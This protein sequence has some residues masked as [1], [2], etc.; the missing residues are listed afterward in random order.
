M[1][2]SR[3]Y[4][5]AQKQSAKKWDSANLDRL[6]LAIPKGKKDVIKA[7]AESTGESVNAFINR[8]IQETMDNDSADRPQ[9]ASGRPLSEG[10]YTLSPDT[11]A[12][13]QMVAEA[14]GEDIPQ[15]ITRAIDTQIQRDKLSLQLGINPAIGDKLE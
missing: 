14:T 7:H 3:K 13:A 12:S 2:T 11:L 10:S 8:A 4:T 9:E 1:P 6:S 15:F 5:E